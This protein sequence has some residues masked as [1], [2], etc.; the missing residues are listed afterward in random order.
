MC[1]VVVVD[2]FSRF[3]LYNDE[4]GRKVTDCW[5]ISLDQL[6]KCSSVK[7]TYVRLV[8]NECGSVPRRRVL[9]YVRSV[10]DEVEISIDVSTVRY[11]F[12]VSTAFECA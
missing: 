7:Y 8:T 1:V 3:L 6:R 9:T 11:R 4:E 5:G 2:V 10:F 12:L